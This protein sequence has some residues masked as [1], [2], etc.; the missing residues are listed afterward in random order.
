MKL[1]RLYEMAVECGIEADPRGEK[2]VK[3][4][5]AKRKADYDSLSAEEKKEFD[6]ESLKNPYSDTRI[7]NGD[8]GSEVKTLLAGIDMET[9]ELLLCRALSEKERIDLVISHHPE[10]KALSALYG[11][12]HIQSDIL[13]N[14]GVPVSVAESLLGERIK[15]VERK[16]MPVNHTR[17]VDAARLLGI[18]FM[19][20][21]TVAD[22][23]VASYLQ[24]LLD[25]SKPRYLGDVLKVIKEIPEYKEAIKEGVGFPKIILGGPEKR[26]GKIFVDMTGGTEGSKSIFK[27]ISEAGIDTLICMHLSEEHFKKAREAHV[28]V[29]IAGHITSDTLGLNLLF[30]KIEKK[31]KLKVIPCSGF[32]RIPRK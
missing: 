32:R 14:L 18:P 28:N 1:G 13:A 21:H 22:N 11:V 30:D 2:S 7:L 26:A 10:G 27:N 6:M 8:P 23:H 15:E 9:P 3:E 19:C 17:C 16:L 25:K 29:I 12:M 5:L 4:E 31:E 20:M 24:G